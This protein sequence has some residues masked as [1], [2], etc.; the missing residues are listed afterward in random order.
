MAL[1]NVW[2]HASVDWAVPG[3]GVFVEVGGFEGRWVAE[4]AARYDG[5]FHVYEPQE[6]AHERIRAA[7][8]AAARPGASLVIHGFGLGAQ[9]AYLPMGGWDTDACSFLKDGAFYTRFPDEGRRKFGYGWLRA[10]ESSGILDIGAVDVMMM[11]IEGYEYILLPAL[12][13][14]GMM[15]RIRHLSVQFHHDYEQ[16]YHEPEIRRAI[17]ETHDL[18][19]EWPALSAWKLR[20]DETHDAAGGMA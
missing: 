13:R 14:A 12:Q 20:E 18:H 17:E 10:I 7:F 9:D 16:S 5:A 3:P 6:W 8:A 19:W 1:H 15:P 11:N 4:M 2:D